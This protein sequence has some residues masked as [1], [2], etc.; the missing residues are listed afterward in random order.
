M[1]FLCYTLLLAVFLGRTGLAAESDEEITKTLNGYKVGQT[2]QEDFRR[3]SGLL[4]TNG[5]IQASPGKRWTL[6]GSSSQ[7]S[8]K[9][10]VSQSFHGY[11]VGGTNGPVMDLRFNDQGKLADMLSAVPVS[12]KSSVIPAMHGDDE[13]IGAIMEK[14]ETAY[15]KGDDEYP[16][17]VLYQQVLWQMGG[18]Q[19]ALAAIK[20]MRAAQKDTQVI[21]WKAVKPYTY[22]RAGKPSR[23][24]ASGTEGRVYAIVPYVTVMKVNGKKITQHSYQLGVR[25]AGG[26]W[27]FVNGDKLT[28]EFLQAYFPD[29]PKNYKL[30]EV[31]AKS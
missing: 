8:F 7:Y 21:S 23:P 5:E 12:A 22:L 1:K 4:A 26:E 18:K 25:M 10:G 17:T 15:E 30:P 20:A 24:Y 31:E 27:E 14:L 6:Y 9:N 19:A 29:F 11:V 13:A 28:P 3:D 2:T 16:L